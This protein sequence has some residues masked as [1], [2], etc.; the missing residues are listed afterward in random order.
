MVAVAGVLLASAGSEAASR[1]EAKLSPNLAAATRGA[2]VTASSEVGRLRGKD[3]RAA[4]AIDGQIGD[5]Y[6]CTAFT[7]KAPHW[8][9]VKLAGPKR[10]NEVVLHVYEQ[11]SVRSCRVERWDGKAWAAVGQM[12]S[13]R[14]PAGSFSP[15]WEFS[16]APAG[17]VRCRFPTVTS[18]RV[19]FSFDKDGSVRLY[20]V[21]VLESPEEAPGSRATA[22]SLDRNASLVRIAFGP[23][24]GSP[25]PAWLAVG[26]TSR[27]TPKQGVGWVGDCRRADCDRCGGA[28]FARGFVAG[29][30]DAGRLRLD[31]PPGRYV[32]ALFATDF[33]LPVRPFR[34]EGAGLAAGRPLATV[35]PGAWEAR[36]FRIEAGPQ[37]V[38]LAFRGDVCW[39][40]N[41][42]VIAPESNLNALLTEAD[43]LEEE[44]ALGSPE[45]M[46]KRKMVA[47]PTPARA[48]A[49]EADRTRGYMFFAG[50]PVARIYPYTRPDA[51]QV[52]RPLAIQATPGELAV[53]TLGLLPLRALFD[54]RL[55]CTD[56]ARP[57]GSPIP[58]SAIDLRVVRC[59]PQIDK[60]P[61]GRGKVQLIP[62]LLE[63][64]QRHPAVCAPEGATRQYWITIRVPARVA[65]GEYR[66][67]LRFSA[68]G[69]PSAAVPVELT[70]LPFQLQT[71]PEKTFFMY[72]ILG[73]FT[74][75][76]IRPLLRDM[77]EHGMTSLAPDLAGT[78]SRKPRGGTPEFDAES[79]RRVLR[80][81]REAGF[82]RPMP[83]GAGGLLAGMGSPE[84]SDEWNQGL[85]DLLR[86][87]RKVQ[88]EVAGQELLFYP[89]DEPFGNDQRLTLAERAMRVARQ[90]RSLRTYC[91]PDHGDIARL[92]S[93]LDVRCYAIGSV[94][95]V[96]QAAAETRKAG[97]AFWWYTN[98][99][100]ELPDVRRYLAGV[101]FWSTGAEGQG[102]WVYQ[103]R[104]RRTRPFQDL[105]GD[106][107]AHD[108]VA[109]PDLDGPIPT[110]QWECIRMGIDDARYLYTLEAA[111]AAH[112]GTAQ[113][114]A[115]ERFLAQ[116][117]AAM[118][119]C[120]KLP[121][122][123]WVLY[124]CPWKPGEFSRL[125]REVVR[126]IL[127]VQRD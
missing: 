34:V 77:R 83:W 119:K 60:T 35:G 50:E 24:D 30:G 3:H 112:R 93:L 13:T 72:S 23:R 116:L 107:H 81:A 42:L 37:G 12:A 111:I 55:A 63:S 47:P 110:V 71:P 57:G 70:V 1:P 22:A 18:D 48:P 44:L 124:D 80:L 54:M 14:R 99:A 45:W 51:Q 87:V 76:E 58:A 106:L 4:A 75:E 29:W 19:R 115:A 39:L 25:M 117:R 31:L 91:T 97:A 36:R 27:Y 113:A 104:W 26:A 8:L 125:R 84:G 11:S 109:Y 118:P 123:T 100:R 96:H 43:R 20:E 103:S 108:Y 28:T 105:E 68:E 21:E 95:D 64:Q 114:A 7:S 17:I 122:N 121:D 94:P 46:T 32:A 16:D 78:W 67:Q 52:G 127:E 126:H 120:V 101:W 41:A 90:E 88:E 10:F 62:E 59:W 69:V 73:D 102:Y 56:L 65:P 98:A 85:A 89:V 74:D 61:A 5:G 9:E 38:E 79:L 40:V 53:A 2:S 92:G 49:T 86:R 82:T 15:A 6:W 33:M 66:G